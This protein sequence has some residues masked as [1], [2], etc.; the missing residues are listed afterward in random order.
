MIPI[1]PHSSEANLEIFW[2][3]DSLYQTPKPSNFEICVH[4]LIVGNNTRGKPEAIVEEGWGTVV[5]P[6]WPP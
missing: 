2:E 5:V 3:Q 6:I 1:K 4:C